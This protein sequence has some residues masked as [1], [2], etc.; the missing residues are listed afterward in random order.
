M[1]FEVTLKARRFSK[2]KGSW[3]QEPKLNVNRFIN[4]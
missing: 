3:W 4:L 1:P 2:E